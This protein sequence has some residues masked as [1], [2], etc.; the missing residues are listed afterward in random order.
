MGKTKNLFKSQFCTACFSGL[1]GGDLYA[2]CV[3]SRTEFGLHAPQNQGVKSGAE[4]GTDNFLSECPQAI[5]TRCAAETYY[6]G[7][8]I[9]T[10]GFT[11]W[12][13]D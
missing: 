3:L 5:N 4:L 9:S 12:T 8:S 7:Y 2:G 1:G 6:V 10:L 11:A 13:F